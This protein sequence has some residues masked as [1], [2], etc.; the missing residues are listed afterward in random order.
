MLLILSRAF[1]SVHG[2]G[3]R[4]DTQNN[5]FVER[6]TQLLCS[7]A[8]YVQHLNTTWTSGG[9]RIFYCASVYGNVLHLPV[10]PDKRLLLSGSLSASRENRNASLVLNESYAVC[11]VVLHDGFYSNHRSALAISVCRVYSAVV[12]VLVDIENSNNRMVGY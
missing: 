5:I 6:N 9:H 7:L 11:I 3:H 4:T 10:W 12:D 8:R 1:W 2:N